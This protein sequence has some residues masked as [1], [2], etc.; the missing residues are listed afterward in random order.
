M[1]NKTKRKIRCGL[2]YTLITIGIAFFVLCNT[3]TIRQIWYEG[4]MSYMN[5]EYCAGEQELVINDT[6]QVYSLIGVGN[7]GEKSNYDLYKGTCQEWTAFHDSLWFENKFLWFCQG[8]GWALVLIEIGILALFIIA[9]PCSICSE[10]TWKDD[11]IEW[12]NN[13][14]DR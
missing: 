8:F 7:K 2:A 6:V 11:I 4:G 12:I 14:K 3:L 13:G 5:N 9:I 1:K 10:L